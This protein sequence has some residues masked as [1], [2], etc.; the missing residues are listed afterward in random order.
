[1]FDEMNC[2][3]CWDVGEEDIEAFR[4]KAIELEAIERDEWEEQQEIFPHSTHKLTLSAYVKPI[5]IIDLKK[6]TTS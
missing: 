3:V 5:Y 4:R 2:V 1:M 6:V